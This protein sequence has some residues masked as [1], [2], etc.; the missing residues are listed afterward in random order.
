MAISFPPES[1]DAP[2]PQFCYPLMVELRE[3]PDAKSMMQR[4][5][6]KPN[7]TV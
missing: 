4:D 7:H 3:K 2:Y 1:W 6:I 5:G